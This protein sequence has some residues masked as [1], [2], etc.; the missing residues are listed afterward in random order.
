MFDFIAENK[1]NA[2]VILV[3]DGSKD[4]GATKLVA[5]NFNCLF[6]SSAQNKGKGNAVRLG[7][8]HA[9]G[10]IRIF[11]DADI[12]FES[13]AILR[14]IDYIVNKEFDLVIGDRG[15]PNSHY[16]DR[17]SSKR[18][19]GSAAFTFFVGRF[20][21]TGFSDTQCGLKGFSAKVADDLFRVGLLNGF[22]FDVELLYISL[23]RNFDIKKI[24]VSLR[25]QDGSSVSVLKH[26]FKMVMDLFRI[27]W[28]HFRGKY[29]SYE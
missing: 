4:N 6:L 20:V 18:R 27:K 3:D 11:T 13:D 19:F 21:T 17:I 29:N 7:M 8:R 14:I 2:E 22:T 23:K 16:F 9:S 1:L 5:K 24:P 26:G 12:P 28:N 15:L 10:D 25:S